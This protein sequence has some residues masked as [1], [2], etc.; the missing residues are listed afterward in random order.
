[1]RRGTIR[2][3]AWDVDG[4]LVDSEPLH[5][6]ALVAVSARHGADLTDL[7][8][9]AFRGVAIEDVWTLL[10]PRFPAGT[11]RA[12][13]LAG[14]MTHYVAHRGELVALP[15]AVATVRALAARGI[16]QACVSNS[17]RP[18][19]DANLDA[20]GIAGAM[21]F[22]ISLDDVAAGKP[23]PEPYARAA[24]RFGLPP[25]AV[26]AVEDSAAGA[27]SARAAGLPV[28]VCGPERAAI[29]AD[30][31]VGALDELVALI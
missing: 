27:A 6:R 5:H 7:P 25:S 19:V 17:N 4:T 26:L 8:D 18:I 14:I 20:L 1:M 2:A 13:W 22:S 21:A 23:D 10:A 16:A 29:D 24:A 31:R 12:D 30:G 15:G 28:I 3:V 11:V 9:M